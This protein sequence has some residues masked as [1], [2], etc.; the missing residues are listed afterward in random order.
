[1]SSFWQRA[2]A[3]TSQGKRHRLRAAH[4]CREAS[5][6]SSGSLSRWNSAVWCVG[7]GTGLGVRV[8]SR[9]IGTVTLHTGPQGVRCRALP[10]LAVDLLL[11]ERQRKCVRRLG[12]RKHDLQQALAAPK[13]QG[14][15]S[16]T[17][18]SWHDS[19]ARG[20][21]VAG[22]RQ[23]SQVAWHWRAAFPICMW[24]LQ[25]TH[26]LVLLLLRLRPCRL[27]CDLGP[28]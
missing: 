18:A 25:A 13:R 6:S 3:R 27:R 16:G 14:L 2:E 23:I 21:C 12:C 4:R 17:G 15:C 24:L 10:G 19:P 5:G 8:R 22:R 9:L 28:C 20:A 11:P 26:D 1:M 7:S